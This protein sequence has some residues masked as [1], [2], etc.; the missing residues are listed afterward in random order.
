MPVKLTGAGNKQ[1]LRADNNDL[2]AEKKLL[3]NNGSK[4]AQKV[5]LAVNNDSIRHD[6][7]KYK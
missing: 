2:L 3:G 1:S 5:A 7:T 6:A 4:S